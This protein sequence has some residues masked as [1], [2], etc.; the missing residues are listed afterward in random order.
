MNWNHSNS[1]LV[2]FTSGEHLRFLT[3]QV[4]QHKQNWILPLQQWTIRW[5]SFSLHSWIGT[6]V[7]AL[8]LGPDDRRV[9]EG[10]TGES[11]L[12]TASWS[13]EEAVGTEMYLCVALSFPVTL[14]YSLFLVVGF[15]FCFVLF[16]LFLFCLFIAFNFLFSSLPGFFPSFSLS[17]QG[18]LSSL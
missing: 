4:Q 10:F 18:L 8:V 1:I 5:K 15:L 16:S 6:I 9:Q 7:A 17:D 11:L 2:T 13:Y 3:A 14:F 12:Q